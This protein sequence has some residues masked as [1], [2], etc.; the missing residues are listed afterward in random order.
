[1]EDACTSVVEGIVWYIGLRLNEL[2]EFDTRTVRGRQMR[3]LQTT[4]FLAEDV[5]LLHFRDLSRPSL[6]SLGFATT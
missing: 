1:V 6:A 4:E 5:L 3:E 2:E